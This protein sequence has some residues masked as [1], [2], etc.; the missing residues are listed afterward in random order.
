[1]YKGT[2]EKVFSRAKRPILES[3]VEAE[4]L[5]PG[6][7]VLGQNMGLGQESP[8]LIRIGRGKSAL[9]SRDQF[10]LMSNGYA[11]FMYHVDL[12]QVYVHPEPLKA[13]EIQSKVKLPPGYDSVKVFIKNSNED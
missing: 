5:V 8:K 10:K 4:C 3:W 7:D 12:G 9:N 2:R 11:C 1:M 6:D 13:E